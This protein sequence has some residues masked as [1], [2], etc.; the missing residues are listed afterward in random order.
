MS[1]SLIL[2]PSSS[3]SAARS[4]LIFRDVLLT[5]KVNVNWYFSICQILFFFHSP[6]YISRSGS[7]GVWARCSS[8]LGTAFGHCRAIRAASRH[9][10]DQVI[11]DQ[12][13]WKIKDMIKCFA[14]VSFKL[15]VYF[16]M[17]IGL[18][19]YGSKSSMEGILRKTFC[20]KDQGQIMV[21]PLFSEVYSCTL[22]L[23]F[24]EYILRINPWITLFWICE[25]YKLHN[26]HNISIHEQSL[27]EETF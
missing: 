15:F 9:L 2:G 24:S 10:I 19:F 14:I 6:R 27:L 26:F 4:M 25:V 12:N 16:H 20:I 23:F 13:V 21:Q 1:L 11:H 8:P 3:S 17:A 5:G 22:L 18:A 7:C